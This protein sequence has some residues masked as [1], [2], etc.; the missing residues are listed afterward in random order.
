M[1]DV[2]KNANESSQVKPYSKFKN[3]WASV[4]AVM[5]QLNYGMLF[6]VFI[7]L[8]KALFSHYI[9]SNNVKVWLQKNKTVKLLIQT[10]V[11]VCVMLLRLC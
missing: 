11:I 4:R 9:T 6:L 10:K 2:R 3:G 8:S 5:I 7:A 1:R